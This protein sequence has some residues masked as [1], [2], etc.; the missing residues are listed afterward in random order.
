[1]VDQPVRPKY[2]EGEFFRARSRTGQAIPFFVDYGGVAI[3]VEGEFSGRRWKQV[4]EDFAPDLGRDAKKRRVI[5]QGG[6]R[7]G[8][9]NLRFD[10]RFFGSPLDRTVQ[11]LWSR[12]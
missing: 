11:F 6:Y 9:R 7:F 3:R 1:M 10:N 4:P 5:V 2:V 12:S 8:N